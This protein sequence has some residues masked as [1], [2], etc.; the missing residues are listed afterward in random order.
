MNSTLTP[1]LDFGRVNTLRIDRFAV[2]GAYLMAKDGS[3]VLLPN[4]YVTDAM[5]IDDLLEVFVYTDSE[6]RPVAT[7][8]QPTA[9]RDEFG[10]FTVVDVAKFGAFVDWGLP[11][12]L[13]V[14]KNR[15]KTPFKVGEKRFL[16]VVKDEESDRLVGVERISKYL[17]HSPRGYHPN[18]EVKLLFIAKTPLGFKVIVDDAYEGLAFDNEIFEPV[19]VGDSRTGYVKQVRADGNFDVS[20]QP[21]GKT[22]R[23][24]SDQAK[25][26]G[27]LDAAGGMLP[28]N[29]KSDADLITKTF[30]LSKKAFKRA[31]VQLQESG[32][33]EVKETGIYR[34]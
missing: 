29:S 10:F 6:D 14:P 22:A 18:K 26:L 11:K 33:I 27:P 5:A 23:A 13:L 21:V 20:L 3:D 16:R 25:V 15:Q 12:D 31:L 4:Q 2:P 30:G 19:A 34:K 1:T 9:M 32:D 8:D 7:T 24:G 28:Y 17:S